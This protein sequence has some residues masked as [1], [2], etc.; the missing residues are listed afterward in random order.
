[1]LISDW[2]SDVCSSD[3]LFV[4]VTENDYDKLKGKW[5]KITKPLDK[6]KLKP[7]RFLRY[8][9]MANYPVGQDVVREDQ[10]YEWFTTP[11]NIDATGYKKD[12]MKFVQEL[13]V[14]AQW[15]V[16]IN[17]RK[18]PDGTDCRPLD[19]LRVMRSEEHTS[20]LQSLM[21]IS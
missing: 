17:A 2:S 4:E 3:L 15:Y 20:E 16:N 9:I 19:R 18:R 13:V 8:F 7:L 6:A 14:S 5:E 12:P 10:I 11:S 1:M 21:P